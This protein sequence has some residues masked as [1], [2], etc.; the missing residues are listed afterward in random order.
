MLGW[1]TDLYSVSVAVM[2]MTF[3]GIPAATALYLFLEFRLEE[4]Y[5]MLALTSAVFFLGS[6]MLMRSSLP[7]QY[8]NAAVVGAVSGAVGFVVLV[9]PVRETV[10]AGGEIGNEN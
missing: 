10:A 4:S 8:F 5:Y 9:E 2:S 6:Y 1:T 3:I 7:G